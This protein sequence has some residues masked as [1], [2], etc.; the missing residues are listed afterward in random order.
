MGG[1]S[2]RASSLW[3]LDTIFLLYDKTHVNNNPAPLPSAPSCTL[4]IRTVVAPAYTLQPTRTSTLFRLR[5]RAARSALHHSLNG[6][7][8]F[9]VCCGRNQRQRLTGRLRR[10]LVSCGRVMALCTSAFPLHSYPSIAIFPTTTL[11]YT[12]LL[13]LSL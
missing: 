10:R 8:I 6:T 2:T 12:T 13:A 9:R 3:H 4:S 1:E 11:R 7:C 5:Q